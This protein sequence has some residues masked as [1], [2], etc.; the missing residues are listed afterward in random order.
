M[1]NFQS[2]IIRDAKKE[3]DQENKK[4]KHE[5]KVNKNLSFAYMKDRFIKIL[6]SDDPRYYE[7]LK[8]LFKIEP[9]PIRKARKFNRRKK[10]EQKKY[11]LNKRRAV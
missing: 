4:R 6:L 3:M 7:Q 5:Y 8:E 10:R 2:L 9:V 1:A 11:L